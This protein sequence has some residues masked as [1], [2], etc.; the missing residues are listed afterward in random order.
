MFSQKC[1][2]HIDDR[3][4]ADE[5]INIVNEIYRKNGADKIEEIFFTPVC[6]SENHQND[7]NDSKNNEFDQF[8]QYFV[9]SWTRFF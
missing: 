4:S 2:Y 8:A 9:L 7:K 1:Q 6:S 5:F 3:Y